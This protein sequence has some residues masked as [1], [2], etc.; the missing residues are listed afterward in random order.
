MDTLNRVEIWAV[1]ILPVSLVGLRT[2]EH[3][4]T[5]A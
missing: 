3:G 5:T 4:W 2:W 1:S